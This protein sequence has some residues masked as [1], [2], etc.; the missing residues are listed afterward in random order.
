MKVFRQAAFQL[1]VKW[2]LAGTSVFYII[3]SFTFWDL[4]M[5]NWSSTGRG[6]FIFLVVAMTFF[7]YF[8]TKDALTQIEAQINGDPPEPGK[9]TKWQERLE[10]VQAAQAKAEKQKKEQDKK[11]SL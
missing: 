6:F 7:I 4:R 3:F 9:K 10:Q 8:I 2:F 1:S 5:V 11:N